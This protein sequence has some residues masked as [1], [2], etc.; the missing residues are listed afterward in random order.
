ML[1]LGFTSASEALA[2]GHSFLSTASSSWSPHGTVSSAASPEEQTES[3]EV[4]ELS[5]LRIRGRVSTIIPTG[6]HC[7]LTEVKE[8]PELFKALLPQ[9]GTCLSNSLLHGSVPFLLI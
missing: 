4:F 3:W 1:R 7:S 8:E 2:L 9:D 6:L 5:L